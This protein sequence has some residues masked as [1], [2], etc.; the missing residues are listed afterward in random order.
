MGSRRAVAAAVAVLAAMVVP[1]AEGSVKVVG[2]AVAPRLCVTRAGVAQ[3]TWRDAARTS[4]RSAV[5]RRDGTLAFD[6]RACRR[7]RARVVTGLRVPMAV[8]VVRDRRGR[9][10]A[11]QAWRRLIGGPVEL[12]YSRWRGAPTRLRLRSDPGPR[13]L[14]ERVRGGLS[15]HGR[16]V[17]GYRSTPQGVPLDRYGRNVYL[18]SR[19]DG[20]WRRMMG[21]LTHRPTG[22]FALWIRPHWEGKRYRGRVIG[23]NYGWTL[24]PDAQAIAPSGRR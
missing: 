1:V 18:D 13:R 9:F 11:L 5:V 16:P 3:I 10:H 2:D 19:Q 23:P 4:S 20:A 17:H 21:I 12:R 8:V 7:S 22:F 24:A 6:R 14:E 15:Y